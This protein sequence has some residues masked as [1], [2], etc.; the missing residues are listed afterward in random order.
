MLEK[1]SE[2]AGVLETARYREIASGAFYTA[3]QSKTDDPGARALM[4]DLAAEEARH[5]RWLSE[6][7]E[8]GEARKRPDMVKDLMRNEYLTGGETLE[9][10]GLQGT[11]IFAIKREQASVDFY[12]RLTAIMTTAAGKEMCERLAAEEL[13]HKVKIELLYESLF[14]PED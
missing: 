4:K 12:S 3:G 13:R 9:G 10:A 1:T 11:L 7:K 14:Y 5:Y 2:V 6:F 8:T